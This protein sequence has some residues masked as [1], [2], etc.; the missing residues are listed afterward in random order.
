MENKKIIVIFVG[1]LLVLTMLSGVNAFSSDEDE[2]GNPLYIADGKVIV[3]S[4]DIQELFVL[5]PSTEP[6]VPEEGM[7]YFD[8]VSKRLKLYDGEGWYAIALEKV[9]TISKQQVVEKVE[10]KGEVQ[11]CS[12]STECGDWGDCI[13]NYQ[14]MICITVDES[15]NK[16]EDIETRDCVSDFE[17]KSSAK[18]SH[19]VVE[20]DV[21]GS[22]IEVESEAEEVCEEVCEPG[23]EVCKEV[24]SCS[25]EC[26][27]DDKGNEICED[28][29][30][31]EEV[32]E[33][34]EEVCKEVCDVPEALFDITFDLE[35]SSL[36]KSDKLVLWAT[37]QNFGKRYVP[38]RV[39]YAVSDVEGNEVYREFEE[40]RVYTDESII[41]KF[42]NLLLEDG[43]YSLSMSVEYAGII[44][45]FSDSFAVESGFFVSIKRFFSGWF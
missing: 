33:A 24:E 11:T 1:I 38:A 3:P 21:L 40:I 34:G 14:S 6:E 12:E 16:Y 31:V 27:S 18:E 25:E 2:E 22:E 20:E 4:I 37:L 9:S 23:E 28:V 43:E 17:L 10:K 26:S 35:E 5:Q 13:N 15:C 29:C 19:N 30:E 32:C 45:E 42:D 36:S 39:I 8:S 7:V 44:E 41:K